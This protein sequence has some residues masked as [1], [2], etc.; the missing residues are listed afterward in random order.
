MR[1]QQVLALLL[2]GALTMGMSPAAAFAAE[3]VSAL[4]IEDGL[5]AAF[6]GGEEISDESTQD[7][8]AED[9]SAADTPAEPADTP[10]EPP[11]TDPAEPPAADSAE[12]PAADPAEPPAAEPTDTPAEPADTPAAEPT[13]APAENPMAAPEGNLSPESTA[14][15]TP[16][17]T[18]AGAF[19][20]GG[21]DYSTLMEAIIASQ[22]VP[23]GDA[24]LIYI[25]EDLEIDADTMISVPAGKNIVIAAPTGKTVNITRKAGYAGNMIEVKGGDLQLGY[26][27]VDEGGNEAFGTLN[28]NGKGDGSVSSG[29]IVSVTEGGWLGLENV[30]LTGNTTGGN[31]GAVNCTSGTVI[32]SGGSITGNAAQGQGGA[33]Y[34]DSTVYVAGSVNIS[35]NTGAAGTDNITLNNTADETDPDLT[36]VVDICAPLSGSSIGLKL[37]NPAS[38]IPAVTVSYE[39]EEGKTPEEILAAALPQFIYDDAK[40]SIDETGALKSAE[41]PPAEKLELTLKNDPKWLSTNRVQINGVSTKDADAYIKVVKKGSKALTAEQIISANQKLKGGVTANKEFAFAHTF[42]KTEKEEVGSDA[43]TV[44]ICVA[45]AERNTA[46]SSVDMNVTARPPKVT[47]V[48]A[49]T[50]WTGHNSAN[51]VCISDKA[52]SYYW[53]WSVRSEASTSASSKTPE[54]DFSK[55]GVPV[56]ANKNFTVYANDLD[57]DHPIDIYVYVKGEDG[58][59][60]APVVAKMNEANRPPAASPTVTPSRQP[61]N[62]SVSESTVSGLENPLEF[63]P[64]TF[65]DFTV[66][67]AG[68][69]NNDP[70]EGDTRWVPLYWSMS[71]NPADKDK[72]SSWRIGAKGGI[73]EAGTYNLY[74]FFRQDRYN[75]RE[76]QPTDSVVSQVYQFMSAAIDYSL[77]PTPTII[78]G[79]YGYDENGNPVDEYGNPIVRDDDEEETGSTAA[80]G[81]ETADDSPVGT[82]SMLAVL[83]LLAGGYVITRKRKKVTE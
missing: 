29:S 37:V 58:S 83:S 7:T 69:K 25:N 63:Y 23:N 54:I 48:S 15:S 77:S 80:G 19:T 30:T 35:G 66:I 53:G 22:A 49:G 51:V 59:I 75:G 82:M 5:S 67:G 40:F 65:Y 18:L 36:A 34:S 62:P 6:D 68:T 13:Q 73:K 28:I 41:E 31:G 79:T 72:H 3:D 16:T 27:D 9:P 81:A 47:G 2:T 60:S 38:G 52:G 76:W 43:V 71:S 70:I 14:T 39:D 33:I 45:D 8:A 44:Y 55:D 12:P 24:D 46:V 32:V 42:S 21:K 1:K 57:P 74:V 61:I 10:A 20:M 4:S 26:G 64:N 11:A 78:P 17:E 56:A 50:G